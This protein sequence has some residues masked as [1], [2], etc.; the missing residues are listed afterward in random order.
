MTLLENISRAFKH[1]NF[2]SYFIW[3][4]LSFSGT[5]IQG[6]A[7]SWLIYRLTGSAFFLGL[8]AFASSLPGLLFSPVS[9]IVS[10]RFKKRDVLLTTQILCLI[11]S[12][13]LIAL[14]YSGNINKWHI[15]FLSVFIGIANSFDVTARQTF[16]PLLVSKNELLNAIALNSSMFNGAR[17]IGPAVAGILIAEYG[18]GPCF[19]LNSV[20][21][22]FFI[23]FLMVI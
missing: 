6:T 10:D 5:W 21:Y 15:L 23:V 12:V 18:E 4:F 2:S 13:I 9:G 20:S 16:I 14:F 7:L 17:I 11:Q 3:Q 1:K 22:V 19:V 8:V